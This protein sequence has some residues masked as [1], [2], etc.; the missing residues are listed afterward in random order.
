MP[1]WKKGECIREIVE[2]AL[3]KP[4]TVREFI[5]RAIGGGL[6]KKVATRGVYYHLCWYRRR[7]YMQKLPN[8]L[9]QLVKVKK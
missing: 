9:E 8:G 3:S 4:G 5:A 2:A 7:M 6:S 1:R